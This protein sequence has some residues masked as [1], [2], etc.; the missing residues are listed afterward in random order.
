MNS[1]DDIKLVN[2]PTS[3]HPGGV[4]VLFCDSSV[5]FIKETINTSTWRALGTRNGQ[6]VIFRLGLLIARR[7]SRSC[8]SNTIVHAALP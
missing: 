2:P 6:E 3:Y 1:G 8:W 4:N 7:A 5:R